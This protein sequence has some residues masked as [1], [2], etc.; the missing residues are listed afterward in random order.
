[1]Q[2]VIL[3]TITTELIYIVNFYFIIISF[4]DLSKVHKRQK[5]MVKTVSERIV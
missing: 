4:S 5:Q 3:Q 1:M 2:Q